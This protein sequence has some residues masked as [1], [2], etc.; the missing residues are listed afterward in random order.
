MDRKGG[1]GMRESDDRVVPLNVGYHTL[2]PDALHRFNGHE[3]Q[4][5]EQWGID[6]DLLAAWLRES[7]IRDP[8]DIEA[9]I[10]IIHKC[11]PSAWMR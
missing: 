11:R 6:A 9:A 10:A 4:W 3:R 5:W 7:Y 8:R 2:R 1:M